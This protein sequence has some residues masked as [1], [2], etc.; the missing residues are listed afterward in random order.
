MYEDIKKNKI[1][2]GVI[3]TL[4]MV[5][6]TLIIYAICQ[7]FGFSEYAIFFAL[8]FSIISAIATYYNCD[9]IVLASVKA[10]P[11]TKEEDLQLT[12]ILDGLMVASGLEDRPRLY[13]VDS[14]Q[15]N[16][17]ATGRNP[18][19]A[20]ICVTSGLIAKLNYRELEGVVAH[21]L[22]HIKNYDIRLSAVISVMAGF[23]VML[24]DWFTRFRI[25]GRRNNN[26]DS[27]S[28]LDAILMLVGLI[29]LILSPIIS[30]LIQLAVSRRREYLADATAVSFTRN[31][32]GLISALKKISADDSELD[33]A[34][35]SNAFMYIENPFKD[36]RRKP[37]SSLF[38]THPS[39]EERVKALENLR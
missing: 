4:F 25:R 17:F 27:N 24:A 10:R 35:N 16:A 36:K 29:F 1:K 31:P 23:V 39:V 38:S 18:Q 19:N 9:K 20:I 5:M 7:L 33:V 8:L 26:R 2:T 30:N 12:N 3:V 34:S 15:P 11:A 21:E 28:S 32:D 22:S 13:V 37:T 14:A 6:I